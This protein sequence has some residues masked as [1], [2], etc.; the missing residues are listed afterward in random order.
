MDLTDR[1][2]FSTPD[3]VTVEIMYG[4]PWLQKM[5]PF[6]FLGFRSS[7]VF[8]PCQVL[9]SCGKHVTKVL[10]SPGMSWLSDSYR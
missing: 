1:I 9:P 3:F 6:N 8:H 7:I 5:A 10:I 4:M 2:S